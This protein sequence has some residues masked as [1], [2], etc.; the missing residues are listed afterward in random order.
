M[1]LPQEKLQHLVAT[2][3]SWHNRRACTRKELESLIGLLNHACKVVRSGRLFS[4]ACWICSM[5]F[6]APPNSTAPIRLNAGCRSDLLWWR[7]FISEW[8]GIS[9]LLPPANLPQ[10]HLTSDASGSWCCGAWYM[11]SWFPIKWPAG[12]QRLTTAQKELIPIIV[13]CGVWRHQWANA[14]VVCHSDNQVVVA[15]LQA[16]TSRDKGIMHLLC[17]LVFT[18]AWLRCYLTLIYV[19]T[20]D[21]TT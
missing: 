1:R 16:R 19:S 9:F 5:Q 18:V 10:Y 13:A 14:Q 15:A 21:I 3:H 11:S 2:L 17:C 8:N 4:A 7:T 6:T 20:H 12:C